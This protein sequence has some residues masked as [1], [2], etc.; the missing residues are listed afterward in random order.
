MRRTGTARLGSALVVAFA[1]LV[2]LGALPAS[3]EVRGHGR[4]HP[5]TWFGSYATFGGKPWAWC[6]DAG[7]AAPDPGLS[8]SGRRVA[9][10]GVNYLL[11]RHAADTSAQNHGALSYLVHTSTELPHNPRTTVPASPPRLSGI[12][13]PARVAALRADAARH[14]GPYTVR[15]AIDLAADRSSGTVRAALL[16]AAGHPT[17]GWQA[18]VALD[19]PAQLVDGVQPAARTA[20]GDLSWRFRT[21]GSGKVTATVTVAAPG[22]QVTL[23]TASR[24]GV[25]RV[26]TQTGTAPVRGVGHAN[27]VLPFTPTVLTRTSAAVAKAGVE[28]HD[29]LTVAVGEGERWPAGTTAT[30][31]STLWGPFAQRPAEADR[32]PSGAPVVGTV[33]TAVD[34]PGEHRT[35]ALTLPGPGYY[36]WTETI[37]ADDRQRGWVG[38]FGLVGETT[39]VPWVP[40][41]RTQ[42][43]TRTAQP[44]DVVHDSLEVSGLPDD[45]GE[46]DGDDA[47]LEVT[48]HGPFP[49]P[50]GDG[51][52]DADAPVAGRV[53]LVA[54]NGTLVTPPVG[55]LTE[56]GWY[57]FVERLAASERVAAHTGPCGAESETFVVAA[58][59]PPADEPRV[60]APPAAPPPVAPAPVPPAVDVAPQLP[61][62]GTSSMPLALAG[63]ALLAVGAGVLRLGGTGGTGARR[64]GGRHRSGG[65]AAVAPEPAGVDRRVGWVPARPSAPADGTAD[66]GQTSATA[67]LR[68][69]TRR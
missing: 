31:A 47:L 17:P 48:L 9:A 39:L 59:A 19:G 21:T 1:A 34:G 3:A 58:P 35:P 2:G 10:P 29:V 56:P 16:S 44:G 40:S 26:V 38:R 67:R 32:A 22:E 36:V 60:E 15:V 20:A 27:V 46:V 7:R 66:E 18:T 63:G 64:R 13:L 68:A 69:L 55:P 8:W 51:D 6:V 25:Q 12:D 61:R 30:V 43:S 42:A 65:V 57:T 37:A 11:T 14:A 4:A 62:T 54:R 23:H 49:E 24:A 52:C 45:F 53:E 50:P 28:L 41:V 5:A 33:Q